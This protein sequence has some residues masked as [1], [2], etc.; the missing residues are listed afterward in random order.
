MQELPRKE[1][2]YLDLEL[3]KKIQDNK[4]ALDRDGNEVT[5][6]KRVGNPDWKKGQPSPNPFGRPKSIEL[7]RRTNK[8]LREREF[9]MLL[10]KLKPH[11]SK[12][13]M[14]AVGVLDREESADANKLKASAL[15]IGLYK[16]I[17]KEAYNSAYDEAEGEAIQENTPIFSLKVLGDDD[18]VA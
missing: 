17:L 14:A 1:E 6:A 13:V 18:K 9:L 10:R 11:Q 15:L 7:P 5:K 2:Q 8:E 3:D 4:K 12:A 16:D